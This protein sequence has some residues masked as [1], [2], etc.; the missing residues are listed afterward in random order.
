[1]ERLKGLAQVWVIISDLLQE[2]LEVLGSVLKDDVVGT[3]QGFG[4]VD[5]DE[6]CFDFLL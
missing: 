2:A 4:A 3:R 1:L 5:M 6:I